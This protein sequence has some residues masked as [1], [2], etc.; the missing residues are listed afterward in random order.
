MSKNMIKLFMSASVAILFMTLSLNAFAAVP[1]ITGSPEIDT[2]QLLDWPLDIPATSP[3]LSE[4][5]SNRIYDLHARISNCEDTNVVLSTAGNYHMALRDL[6]YDYYLPKTED[7]VRNWYYTTSP[8]VSAEQIQNK[9]LTFG[10][11]RLECTP[12]IAVGPKGLMNNLRNLGM[13]AEEPIAVIRNYGNVILVKKGNPKHIKNIWD[14]GRPNVRVVTSNPDSEPGSFNNY[15]TSIFDIADNDPDKPHGMTA[16]K[17]FNSIFNGHNRGYN[18]EHNRKHEGEY[19][20][21]NYDE[22]DDEYYDEYKHRK[23]HSRFNNKWLSGKRIHHREVPWSVAYG[24]ADAGIMFYHLGL[25]MVRTFPDLYDI[26]PLGGTV[27]FPEPVVG[28]RVATL[29][30]AKIN[31]EFNQ[32]QLAAREEL[33]DAYL[34]FDFDVILANHGI[35]RPV[36]FGL[37]IGPVPEKSF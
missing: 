35:R 19:D 2:P 14:L 12:S 33:V 3:D 4:P 34:S 9:S 16:E 20:D 8:P 5:T 26:V 31:G 23:N 29:F 27:E 13:L 22:Y 11:V 24:D 36:G 15:S 6:W 30:I 10:N 7:I 17:L 28:N 37:T 25:Y 21:E 1:A 18:H 32:D